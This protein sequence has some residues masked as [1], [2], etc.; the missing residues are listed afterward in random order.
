[1]KTMRALLTLSLATLFT[2]IAA[3]AHSGHG[4]ISDSGD[5]RDTVLHYVTQPEHAATIGVAILCVGIIG[6]AATAFAR[7]SYS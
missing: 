6:V 4:I 5:A 2:P 3:F 7:R 1:M